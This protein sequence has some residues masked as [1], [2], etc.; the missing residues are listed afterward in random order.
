MPRWDLRNTKKGQQMRHWEQIDRD[1]C[2][3]AFNDASESFKGMIED[4]E[5]I[6]EADFRGLRKE[7]AGTKGDYHLNAKEADSVI[8]ALRKEFQPAA[9]D[10]AA[11]A[12]DSPSMPADVTE[13]DWIADPELPG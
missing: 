5:Q 1:K 8:S 9:T 11:A 12:G 10:T 2:K 7:Y 3:S 4:G 13:E 6:T